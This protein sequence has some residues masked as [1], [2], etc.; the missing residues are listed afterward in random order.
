MGG[1]THEMVSKA[2]KPVSDELLSKH[3]AY[4]PSCMRSVKLNPHLSVSL[5]I[6]VTIC[7]WFPFG[8]TAL[9][10]SSSFAFW[11]GSRP[12]CFFHVNYV[13]LFLMSLVRLFNIII[14]TMVLVC[15]F[16]EPWICSR[17]LLIF[18]SLP[19]VC[20]LPCRFLT[21][22]IREWLLISSKSYF[23]YCD[24]TQETNSKI[25]IIFNM[26]IWLWW[27][28]GIHDGSL[29]LVYLNVFV[30]NVKPKCY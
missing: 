18:S 29:F 8:C 14:T 9:P 6:F 16:L 22:G 28:G 2:G 19:L 7:R 10:S 17:R 23:L 26:R 15:F 1:F 30:F 4:W 5:F 12:Y 27:R 20:L 11:L 25:T 3:K 13:R 24:T 21:A